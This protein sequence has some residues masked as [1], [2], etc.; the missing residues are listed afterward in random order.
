MKETVDGANARR[1]SI[2]EGELIT[3]IVDKALGA[4]FDSAIVHF[5]SK[6]DSFGDKI[7]F[8]KAKFILQKYE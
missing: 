8:T 7:S 1:Q 3:F 6:L 4:E 2:T 5:L